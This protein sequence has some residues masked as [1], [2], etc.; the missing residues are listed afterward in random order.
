MSEQRQIPLKKITR[1]PIILQHLTKIYPGSTIPKQIIKPFYTL[2]EY[3]KNPRDYSHWHLYRDL[4]RIPL[5]RDWKAAT[6]EQKR[7]V[8][9]QIRTMWQ[10]IFHVYAPET[11]I[12]YIQGDLILFGYLIQNGREDI[13][14]N[15]QFVAESL[16][17]IPTEQIPDCPWILYLYFRTHRWPEYT[18]I[19]T[20][21]M[22]W[23]PILHIG[24]LL[25]KYDFP[26][27]FLQPTKQTIR[28]VENNLIDVARR[29]E[30]YYRNHAKAIKT[31]LN[32][33]DHKEGD[34]ARQWE[35]AYSSDMGFVYMTGILPRPPSQQFVPS[36]ASPPPRPL[37]TTTIDSSVVVMLSVFF[38]LFL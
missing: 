3:H 34:W 27:I 6:G 12:E 1:R 29:G 24:R 31:V 13:V 18:R 17:E 5:Y 19:R 2:F 38:L 7:Q 14:L 9:D 25:S 15:R 22:L 20:L 33:K 21:Y 37:E 32:K 30:M 26:T 16:A 36:A 28:D 11:G 8:E 35:N 23:N 10:M 4:D